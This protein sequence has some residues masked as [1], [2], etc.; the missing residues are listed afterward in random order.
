MPSCRK[1]DVVR[2]HS[3]IHHCSRCGRCVEYMDHHCGITD[4]CVGK[5]N[6]K[7]FFHFTGWAFVALTFGIG[8]VVYKVYT[9]NQETGVGL[10]RVSDMAVI[11]NPTHILTHIK[12]NNGKFN[13]VM[14]P[15]CVFLGVLIVLLTVVMAPMISTILN[16]MNNTDEVKKLK[17]RVKPVN[18]CG[19]G[20]NEV[21]Q[22][23]LTLSELF[24]FI[25]GKETTVLKALFAS[26]L[27]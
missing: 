19:Q 14:L 17:S 11:M 13:F 26:Y 9:W 15:D 25:Y 4:N 5:A 6:A 12:E 22:R 20:N 21:D 2:V 1:C 23:R 3:R 7:Y 10:Q 16:I 24:I 18:E 8:L 27:L